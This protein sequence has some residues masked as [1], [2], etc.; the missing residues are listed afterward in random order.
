MNESIWVS[1]SEFLGRPIDRRCIGTK[2]LLYEFLLS[3]LGRGPGS[4]NDFV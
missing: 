3:I 1:F 4:V 2:V